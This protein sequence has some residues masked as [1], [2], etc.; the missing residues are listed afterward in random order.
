MLRRRRG[1]SRGSSSSILLGLGLGGHVFEAE[2][3]GLEEV[4][5]DGGALPVTAEAIDD[6]DVDLGAVERAVARVELPF[7]GIVLF[8]G[9]FELLEGGEE[10]SVRRVTG[11]GR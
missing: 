6:G 5:L 11:E 8:E 2:V 3:L 1:L 9:L 4:E 10:R 7:A